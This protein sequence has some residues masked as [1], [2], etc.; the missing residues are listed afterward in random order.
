[1]TE[2]GHIVAPVIGGWLVV[3]WFT[4]DY[5]LLAT[6][7]AFDL[8]RVG[9]PYHL[10]AEPFTSLTFHA[11]TRYKP[12][13]VRQAWHDYPDRTLI[14]LDVDCQVLDRID[15]LAKVPGDIGHWLKSRVRSGGHVRFR[16][17]D[18]IMVLHPTPGARKFVQL[19]QDQCDRTDL[20]HNGCSEWTHSHALAQCSGV[21][22]SQLPV[23]YAAQEVD[24]APADAVIVHRSEHRR[25]HGRS[26]RNAAL[27]QA[28]KL[29]ALLSG[30]AA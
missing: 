19:W 21:A 11:M 9:A 3:G 28:R 12:A 16:V 8:D 20:P 13:I 17:A 6:N 27:F 29:R 7:L 10:Y 1:M 15:E 23:A 14:L 30:R 25:R 5:R 4:P 22:F 2:E 26:L 18:R 24:E